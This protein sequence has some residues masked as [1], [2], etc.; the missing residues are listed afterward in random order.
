M[1][2]N[3]LHLYY[4]LLNLYG[5]DANIKILKKQLEEQ[6]IK[7]NISF[8]TIN[9]D[10][11]FSEYDFLFIGPGNID[12]NIFNHL[13]KYKNDIKKYIENNKF[14]LVIGNCINIFGKSITTKNNKYKG[15]N[16]FNFDVNEEYFLINDECLFNMSLLDTKIIG[17]KNQ[18]TSI[19]NNEYPL[20]EV[21]I[22]TGAYPKSEYEG[23]KYKNFYGTY[24]YGPILIKNPT[25]LK[26][27]I[28]EIIKQK[29][30]NFKF[31][32]MNLYFETKAYNNNIDLLKEIT[33]NSINV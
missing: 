10:I 30:E 5:E 16:I 25:L 8:K 26:Y 23:I 4:D 9:D 12:N 31:K 14:M 17:Y 6:G 21:L 3:V 1:E 7:V 29:D 19:I 15:L 13:L 18:T 33:Q 24:L 11:D 27:F 22:G 28:K 2:I 32:K 20:F